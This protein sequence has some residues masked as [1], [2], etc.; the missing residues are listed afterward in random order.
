VRRRPPVPLDLGGQRSDGVFIPSRARGERCLP[1]DPAR[2][3]TGELAPHLRFVKTGP[4]SSRI[5]L[6]NADQLAVIRGLVFTMSLE[7]YSVVDDPLSIVQDGPRVV[8]RWHAVSDCW[9]V[10]AS[11]VLHI[12]E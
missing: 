1:A 12:G 9:I 6:A 8:S 11:A 10:K 7:S 3:A 5:E 4:E 2:S